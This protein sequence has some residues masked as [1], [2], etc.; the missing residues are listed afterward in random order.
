MGL[1]NAQYDLLA[2]RYD[3]KRRAAAFALDER[4]KKIYA[5]I[6]E[7]REIDDNIASESIRRA[8]LAI[9]GDKSALDSIDDDNNA[10]KAKKE[11]LLV[12]HGYPAGYLT[13]QY[14]CPICKDTG[15]VAGQPCDCYKRALSELIY[16]D[17]NL[18][19]ILKEENF[20]KFNIDLFS[21]SPEDIDPNLNLTP[22]ENIRRVVNTAK[23]FIRNFD[24]RFEN[25]L[26]YGNTGVGKTFLCSCIA[27]E[28]LD[29]SHTV[30]YYTAYKFFKYLENDKFR[31]DEADENLRFGSDYLVNCDLLI[32]DDLGT[33][34]TNS[35]TIS[36]LYSVL[37]E[38]ELK[39]H[40][41]V[42]STNLHLGNINS[43]YTER[44]F[45]RL[46]KDYTFLKI[47]GK[48]IRCL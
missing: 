16:N 23:D 22:R 28:L 14:D 34:L 47:F 1:T 5:E 8:R 37:N 45:S 48:D 38:R 31:P 35:F 32:L 25:L 46:S 26:I 40:S 7:I 39:Q 6:P 13:A 12:A 18:A 24:D 44:I 30:V 20:E 43:R 33:E 17:S 21:D 4:I 3:S 29:T 19:G 36:A 42:I 15:S 10:L 11:Q 9:K 27:K 2:Y 41:T